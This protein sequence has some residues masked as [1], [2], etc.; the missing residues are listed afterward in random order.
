MGVSIIISHKRFGTHTDC[1]APSL[2]MC[3]NSTIPPPPPTHT[4]THLLSSDI[5]LILSVCESRKE[6]C[7]FSLSC[8]LSLWS[9][10]VIS[11]ARTVVADSCLQWLMDRYTDDTKLC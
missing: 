3:K 5:F 2:H 7:D 10:P 9:D 8:L 6:V 1:H 4:H 11:E